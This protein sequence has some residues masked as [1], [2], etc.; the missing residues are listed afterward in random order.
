MKTQAK[1]FSIIGLFVAFI[2]C[3]LL[4][5]VPYITTAYAQ[6]TQNPVQIEG[7]TGT[8]TA[9]DPV[10]VDEYSELVAAVNADVTNIKLTKRLYELLPGAEL[11]DGY[12]LNF[13]G[14]KEYNLDLNGYSIEFRNLY[15]KY[16]DEDISFITVAKNNTLNIKN[17]DIQFTNEYAEVNIAPCFV[18][19]LGNLYS[20]DV[21]YYLNTEGCAV[22][23][24]N[25]NNVEFDG[26]TIRAYLGFAV[27]GYAQNLTLD[28]GVILTTEDSAGYIGAVPK[29][30]KGAMCYYGENLTLYKSSF[31]GGVFVTDIEEFDVNE[32]DV[33]I[34]NVKLTSEI[35]KP[36]NVSDA[37]NHGGTYFWKNDTTMGL[38]VDYLATFNGTTFDYCDDLI[39][40]TDYNR[41]F[42][43][44][45]TN[46]GKAYKMVE[47]EKTYITTANYGETF[48]VQQEMP[49]TEEFLEFVSWSSNVSLTNDQKRYSTFEF[50]M[51]YGDVTF[52]QNFI[53]LSKQIDD[54]SLSIGGLQTGTN[55]YPEVI[56]SDDRYTV[57]EYTWYM[58]DGYSSSWKPVDGTDLIILIQ[59]STSYAVEVVLTRTGDYFFSDT[60]VMIDISDYDVTSSENDETTLTMF[61]EYESSLYGSNESVGFTS[62]SNYN[63]FGTATVNVTEKLGDGYEEY[64]DVTYAWYRNAILMEDVTGNS[65]TFQRDD[66]GAKFAVIMTA[67]DK[68]NPYSTTYYSNIVTCGN[69][70]GGIKLNVSDIYE[71]MPVGDVSVT[72]DGFDSEI[73]TSWMYR[74]NGNNQPYNGATLVSGKDYV[75]FISIERPSGYEFLPNPFIPT[76]YIDDCFTVTAQNNTSSISVWAQYTEPL[77]K[78]DFDVIFTADSSASQGDYLK[79][80]TEAMK[81]A[82]SDFATAYEA[83]Q[84]TYQ[85]YRDGKAVEGAT[86]DKY[87]ISDKDL[88]CKI[89]VKVTAGEKFG[90]SEAKQAAAIASLDFTMPIPVVGEK[91]IDYTK[92]SVV[93]KNGKVY[94]MYV[95]WTEPSGWDADSVFEAGVE[96]KLLIQLETLNGYYF[97]PFSATTDFNA[98]K[99]NIKINGVE[100]NKIEGYSNGFSN[101]MWISQIFTPIE[102]HTH[103]GVKQDGKAAGCTEN[104]WNEYYACECGKFFTDSACT[105]EIIDLAAWKD[106]DGKIP[107]AHTSTEFT[108]TTN[109]DGTHTKKHACCGTLVGN[110]NCS[111]GTATC[112]T[113]KTCEKCNT[114]YGDTLTHSHGSAWEKDETGHWNECTCGDKANFAEHNP[115]RANATETDPIKCTICEYIITPALGHTTHTP[116]VEWE[117]DENNHWHDCTG[118]S[119]Q[120][121]EKAQHVDS[122]NNGKCDTCEYDMP[123]TPGGGSGSETPEKPDEPKDGLGVGAIIGIVVGAIAVLGGGGFAIFWFVIK[124]KKQ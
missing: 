52:T 51:P 110:E 28:G 102:N 31:Y 83:G 65:Y 12:L 105:T 97:G 2:A 15:N 103:V 119:G 76:I 120:E 21:N 1:R 112:T 59:G 85:W 33:R 39:S 53:D 108:Y 17:G 89:F 4:A 34:D 107:A 42:N 47:G 94:A 124:K 8:G 95:V 72:V 100:A 22:Y 32:K 35:Y 122:D 36:K 54:G 88:N 55:N 63:L 115:D 101:Q 26:G 14:G 46:G 121:L 106:G 86:E 20:E 62:D 90:I 116:K 109:N 81:T 80:D 11:P 117:S 70:I 43:V 5:F 50:T 56:S 30:T 87:L 38:G 16:M 48:F 27:Y 67:T 25:A 60:S 45:F 37:S 77:K 111:G 18:N 49:D 92:E 10:L 57:T 91:L 64:Y 29:D 58:K 96:Y 69:K 19:V 118:C 41:E 79:I 74:Q 93:E 7:T 104:G 99:A 68:E 123:T 61:C 78:S 3:L 23:L 13:N 24:T 75:L 44:T 113:K 82:S 40:V 9:E 114:A 98:Y 73:E 84:V 66:A 6:E 71:M